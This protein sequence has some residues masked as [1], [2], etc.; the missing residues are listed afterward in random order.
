M[1]FSV[2]SPNDGRA[3]LRATS[4]NLSRPAFAVSSNCSMAKSM[5]FFCVSIYFSAPSRATFVNTSM[6]S[7]GGLW[8]RLSPFV[9]AVT[10]CVAKSK[11]FFSLSTNPSIPRRASSATCAA[12]QQ[13]SIFA[14]RLGHGVRLLGR[15]IQ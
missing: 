14:V 10:S 2:S 13:L 11:N 7:R 4:L 1:L 6:R 3:S 8:V 12:G 15:C 9:A 5:S